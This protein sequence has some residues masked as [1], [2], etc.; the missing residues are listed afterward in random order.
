MPFVFEKQPGGRLTSEQLAVYTATLARR[1]PILKASRD[2]LSAVQDPHTV[3]VGSVEFV[4][5]L[6]ARWGA[7]EHLLAVT[8]SNYPETLHGFLARKPVLTTWGTARSSLQPLF[9]KPGSSRALKVFTGQVFSPTDFAGRHYPDD[10]PVWVCAPL[11]PLRSE[12]RV[13]ILRGGILGMGRYDDSEDEAA[14][15]DIATISAMVAALGPSAPAGYALDVAVCNG[16]TILIE[17]T[18]GWAIGYYRG[19]CPAAEYTTLL[20]ARWHEIMAE[21]DS[22][23]MQP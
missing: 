17:A 8:L 6:A 9:V 2:D 18:D 4:R 12:H 13:Y 1:T 15:P 14:F 23:G 19:T 21:V 20:T 16:H 7:E 22:P 10:L 3:P 5:A 11:P